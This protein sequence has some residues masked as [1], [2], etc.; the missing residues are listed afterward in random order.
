MLGGMPT[1]IALIEA[2]AA[3]CQ[4]L[5]VPADLSA[6]LAQ[7]SDRLLALI[8]RQPGDKAGKAAL[9]RQMAVVVE[10][11]SVS[12]GCAWQRDMWEEVKGGNAS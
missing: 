1:T 7:E 3:E 6:D 11:F 9:R 2:M 4:R 10:T 12:V 8:A 5:K